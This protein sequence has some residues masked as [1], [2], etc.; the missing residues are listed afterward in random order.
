[1]PALGQCKST[2]K[3]GLRVRQSRMGVLRVKEQLLRPGTQRRN[4]KNTLLS[5]GHVMVRHPDWD[6]A[7]KMA[8][9]AATDITMYA[10]G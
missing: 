10:G 8:F 5:D 7:H 2:R 6:E 4:W 3:S 9:A 1:M